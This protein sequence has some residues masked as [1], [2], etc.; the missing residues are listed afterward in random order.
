[1]NTL[2]HELRDVTTLMLERY[3]IMGYLILGI[4]VLIL[5]LFSPLLALGM[6]LEAVV[7]RK[8]EVVS[9]KKTMDNHR[10]GMT[11]LSSERSVN[12]YEAKI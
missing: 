6:I 7:I 8:T 2:M 12:G 10:A 5:V 9:F 11:S 4:I 1:M 3:G